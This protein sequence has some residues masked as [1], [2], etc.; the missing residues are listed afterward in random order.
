MKR[1]LTLFT[2]CLSWRRVKC[3][4]KNLEDV[5]STLKAWETSQPGFAEHVR[6]QAFEDVVDRCGGQNAFNPMIREM[7]DFD[8]YR[9]WFDEGLKHR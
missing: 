8:F 4:S 2:R 5:R 3:G 9:E 1:M 6:F 7:L